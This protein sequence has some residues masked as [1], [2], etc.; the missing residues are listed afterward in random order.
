MNDGD[1]VS[2]FMNR[3]HWISRKREAVTVLLLMPPSAAA[4]STYVF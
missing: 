2:A 3:H 4:A 1:E